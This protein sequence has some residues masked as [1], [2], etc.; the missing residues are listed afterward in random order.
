MRSMALVLILAA[1]G[2]SAS[3]PIDAAMEPDAPASPGCIATSPYSPGQPVDR[4]L[5]VGGR[6][7]T[8]RVRLPAGYTGGPTPLVFALHGG[9][10]SGEQ[11][12]TAQAGLDPIADREGF[13]LVYPDG[14]ARNETATGPLGQARTWN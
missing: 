2:D 10:G 5:T 7:R 1:C 11:L 12:E 3:N 9:F 6:S 8:Y 14:I 13:A 4:T